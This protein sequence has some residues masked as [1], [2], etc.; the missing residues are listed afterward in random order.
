M[1]DCIDTALSNFGA[2][3]SS[4]DPVGENPIAPDLK[5]V[6]YRVGVREGGQDEFDFMLGVLPSLTVA[7]DVQKVIYGLAESTDADNLVTLLDLTIEA[8]SVIR[9]QVQTELQMH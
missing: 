9:S 6:T 8:D 4:S 7:Q 5:Q 2:W 3:M 1:Q